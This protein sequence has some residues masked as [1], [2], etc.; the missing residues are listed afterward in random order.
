MRPL[1]PV[2]SY[3]LLI[4]CVIVS[5]P[6]WSKAATRAVVV[7][8]NSRATAVSTAGWGLETSAAPVPECVKWSSSWMALCRLPWM[9]HPRNEAT[10]SACITGWWDMI[11]SLLSPFRIIR[12]SWTRAGTAKKSRREWIRWNFPLRSCALSHRDHRFYLQLRQR[13]AL[14]SWE[15][16]QVMALSSEYE[17]PGNKHSFYTLYKWILWELG[18]L[19]GLEKSCSSLSAFHL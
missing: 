12:S 7:G 10:Q 19:C 6:V 11:G 5:G 18:W 13:D 17:R 4:S 1:W 16:R 8:L 14:S 15:G 9:K 3:I 2:I